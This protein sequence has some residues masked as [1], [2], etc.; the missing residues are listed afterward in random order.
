[1]AFGKAKEKMGKGDFGAVQYHNSESEG[2]T[3]A[4]QIEGVTETM[5]EVDSSEMEIV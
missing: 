3:Q 2:W 4:G 5:G 1:V